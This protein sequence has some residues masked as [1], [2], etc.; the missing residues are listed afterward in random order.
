MYTETFW[1][2]PWGRE[3]TQ[4]SHKRSLGL[5]ESLLRIELLHQIAASPPRFSSAS[6]DA[7]VTTRSNDASI[8]FL[9]FFPR[10]PLMP[11]DINEIIPLRG[12]GDHRTQIQG[13]SQQEPPTP[14]PSL[15]PLFRPQNAQP[16]P[17]PKNLGLSPKAANQRYLHPVTHTRHCLRPNRP[18]PATFKPLPTCP[19]SRPS[20]ASP[21]LLPFSFLACEILSAPRLRH[22][23]EP[24]HRGLRQM[25]PSQ[26]HISVISVIVPSSLG[27]NGAHI[28][29]HGQRARFQS[30]EQASRLRGRFPHER[31][32]KRSRTHS[33]RLPQQSRHPRVIRLIADPLSTSS[34]RLAPPT[35]HSVWPPRHPTQLLFLKYS[36]VR[37]RLST[38]RT[39]DSHYVRAS[40]QPTFGLDA[41]ARTLDNQCVR[42]PNS[43]RSASTFLLE[44]STL[45]L[46][47]PART[48]NVRPRRSCSQAR[49]S[50]RA[51]AQQPTFGLDVPVRALD[52]RPRRSRIRT[53]DNTC[54]RATKHSAVRPRLW[55][56]TLDT[57]CGRA[58]KQKTV[59][60]ALECERS[61]RHG[62]GHSTTQVTFVLSAS[63]FSHL[64]HSATSLNNVRP[65]LASTVRPPGIHSR[66]PMFALEHPAASSK[67]TFGLDVQGVERSTI[68]VDERPSIQPFVLAFGFER[69]TLNVDERSNKRPFSSPLNANAR[70]TTAT[71]NS[72][73]S[74]IRP[75]QQFG[76]ESQQRSAIFGLDRSATSGH[77]KSDHPEVLLNP[78]ADVRPRTPSCIEQHVH[79]GIHSRWPMFALEHPAASSNTDT[80]PLADVRPR[81]PRCIEQ[82]DTLNARHSIINERPLSQSFGLNARQTIV[83]ERPLSQSFGLSARQ[84]IVNERPL[85]QSFGLSARHSIVN[86]RPLSQSFGLNARQTIINERPL[87]PRFPFSPALI[88]IFLCC[89][90][91]E[92]IISIVSHFVELLFLYDCGLAESGGVVATSGLRERGY[93]RVVALVK[94]WVFTAH[95]MPRFTGNRSIM[96]ALVEQSSQGQF[97]PEGRQD[98]L[99]AAIGRP[100]H[101]GRVRAAGPGTQEQQKIPLSEDD[102]LSSLHLLADILDDK[103]LEVEYDANVFGT[104][105]KVPIYLNSQDVC[106]LASGTQELNISII[107]LWT[108]YMSGVSN[109]LGRSDDYGFIDPQS[110]HESNDFEH[111]NMSAIGNFLLSMQDN[112]ALW[113][114]SLHRPPPTQLRQ[115]I[116]W[117]SHSSMDKLSSSGIQ[118]LGSPRT[119]ELSISSHS[120]I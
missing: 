1:R 23:K 37:P 61:T 115:A 16:D 97:T 74:T 56:R 108:M 35:H 109:K 62:Y 54:G 60:L 18:P 13:A 53:L 67:P 20:S 46:D 110:I 88:S 44:R 86:E 47:V 91:S 52:V 66:W 9:S 104:G 49:Q 83:N 106:E 48:L 25:P 58:F 72:A 6:R 95:I 29:R 38:S 41:P 14:A 33:P 94:N 63:T 64:N 5:N 82:R 111:I 8:G 15:A 69:S 71:D 10:K 50:V 103:P 85:S 101:P 27:S 36:D 79:K 68:P 21:R 96:D 51:G 90:Q 17:T 4:R 99:A 102:P 100:E 80:L 26:G 24:D 98:I 84:T 57:Q 40:K 112:Y 87:G 19:P 45:G 3:P 89:S 31:S 76:H 28:S 117:P 93:W 92:T 118:S 34:A 55:V 77:L 78:L 30:H 81:T 73:T 11:V 75:P 22:P 43:Q 65:S 113:F 120:A 59:L 7:T 70:H 105:S 114:C 42:A 39:L 2:P 107:Q 12:E 32:P 116:D 119:K